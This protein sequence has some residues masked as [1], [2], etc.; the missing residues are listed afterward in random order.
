MTSPR[1]RAGDEGKGR[2]G[3]KTSLNSSLL[4]VLMLESWKYVT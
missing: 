1:R 3:H 2:L 4:V